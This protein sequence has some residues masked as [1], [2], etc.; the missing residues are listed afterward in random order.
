MMTHTEKYPGNMAT[1]LRG[2]V[3]QVFLGTLRNAL[4]QREKMSFKK[5]IRMNSL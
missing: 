2:T 4:I 3:P 5:Y 1:R